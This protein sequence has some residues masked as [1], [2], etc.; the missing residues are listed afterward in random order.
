MNKFLL[1]FSIIISLVVAG[2]YFGST[3]NSSQ[4]SSADRLSSNQWVDPETVVN[5]ETAKQQF[6]FDM[7][8]LEIFSDG[9]DSREEINEGIVGTSDVTENKMI[10]LLG[11]FETK[12]LKRAHVLIGSDSTIALD[13][14]D[15]IVGD[16]KLA[17]ISQ[18]GI[19]LERQES[20]QVVTLFNPVLELSNLGAN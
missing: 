20:Q 1:E 4:E 3:D 19:I 8:Q 7:M 11:I 12:G 2:V 6:A 5:Y 18:S 9:S 17:E 13:V 15:I 10:R 14:G 16:W